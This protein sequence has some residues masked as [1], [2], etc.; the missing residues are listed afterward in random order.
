MMR[1]RQSLAACMLAR[2]RLRVAEQHR[3]RQNARHRPLR[4]THIASRLAVAQFA[5]FLAFAAACDAPT[6]A[7]PAT[8]YDPTTLSRGKLYRWPSGRQISV[9][10]VVPSVPGPVDLALA[11]REGINAWNAIPRFAEFTLVTA[12]SIS[13]AD[14]VIYD[15]VLAAPVSPGSCSFDASSAAGYTYFCPT[16]SV[17][18]RAEMLP[19][20]ATQ[21]AG[22]AGHVAVVIRVDRGRVTN[23]AGYNA[24]VTHE[25]GHAVGIGAHSD[26]PSDVMFGA[27]IVSTPSARD[28]RT[29]QNLL[30]RLPDITL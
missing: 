3:A 24:V 5:A 1:G 14:V 13:D 29:L 25:L 22:G 4:R 12:T 20:A 21:A 30:G 18:S 8:A 9:W 19:L 7:R 10:V 2:G 6:G 28:A 27:P 11:V 23:Q 15:R 26:Q 16:S 17:P